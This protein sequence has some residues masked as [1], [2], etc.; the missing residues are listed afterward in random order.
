MFAK[1]LEMLKCHQCYHGENAN[2]IPLKGDTFKA[3]S[4]IL[5]EALKKKKKMIKEC[6]HYLESSLLDD[7][8]SKASVFL[9]TVNQAVLLVNDILPD[10]D[11][12]SLFF[13]EKYGSDFKL[14][15]E[16]PVLTEEERKQLP[17]SCLF[18]HWKEEEKKAI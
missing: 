6:I 8:T 4:R 17:L 1:D 9:K 10:E 7:F 15:R 11:K 12:K 16:V 14:N 3:C 5:I 18:P 13:L 2:N